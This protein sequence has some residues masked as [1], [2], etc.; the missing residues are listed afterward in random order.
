MSVRSSALPAALADRRRGRL[1]WLTAAALLLVFLCDAGPELFELTRDGGA[2]RLLT[3]HFTHWTASH[4]FW[5][6]LLFAVF[7]AWCE[8]I[9]R[10]AFVALVASAALA[11]SAAF[12]FTAPQL[13]RYRGLSGIDCALVTFVGLSARRYALLPVAVLAKILLE[14]RFGAL[15]APGGFVNLPAVHLAGV[16]VAAVMATGIRATTRARTGSPAAPAPPTMPRRRPRGWSTPSAP[17]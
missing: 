16:A 17:A 2:W 12:L 1:P 5:D 4:R 8:R 13:D 6:V 10:P 11:G 14:T 3:G 7:G 9:S 15:F